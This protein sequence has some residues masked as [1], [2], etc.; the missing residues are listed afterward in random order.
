MDSYDDALQ[1][2][3]TYF[4]DSKYDQ[5]E[6]LLNQMILQNQKSPEIFHMLGTIYYDQ[7]K[8][9]KAIRAFRRALDLDPRFTD[10]SVGLSIILNDIGRYDEGKQVFEEARAFLQQRKDQD[11]PYI[12]EKLSV[13]HDEL[14][15]L[16]FQYGRFR[17]SLEQYER[18]LS[19]SSRKPELTMK[20]VECLLKVG[21]GKSAI[22]ALIDLIRDYPR[23]VGAR[24]KLGQI[25]YE[26]GQVAEAVEQWEWILEQDPENQ[27]AQRLLKQAQSVE[28]TSPLDVLL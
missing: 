21:E 26:I 14:G 23:F 5:A 7:G 4:Q 2:A 10:A 15:E 13:K 12:N 3:K 24:L 25:Y 1:L 9:S 17:E 19:L 8:F 11:D 16:Y 22:Q 28:L 20:R 18:A 6:P 27:E